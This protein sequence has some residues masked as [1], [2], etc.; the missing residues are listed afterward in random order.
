M[1]RHVVPIVGRGGG[2]VLRRTAGLLVVLIAAGGLAAVDP[3]VA[4]GVPGP[5][6][7]DTVRPAAGTSG[8][9]GGLWPG[10]LVGPYHWLYGVV[11][12]DGS[13]GLAVGVGGVHAA[14]ARRFDGAR[15]VPSHPVA[16]P[17]SPLVG[18][19]ALSADDAWAVGGW[20]DGSALAEHWDGTRWRRVKTPPP[21]PYSHDELTSVTMVSTDDVWAAGFNN[22]SEGWL[23]AIID[24]WDGR[25]WRVALRLPPVRGYNGSFNGISA[26]SADDVWAVGGGVPKTGYL[27]EHWDGHVWTPITVPTP[28]GT[29][30][31]GFDSVDVRSANDVWAVG[32]QYVDHV[33]KTAIVHWNGK[34]WSLV[35]SPNSP[36]LEYPDNELTGVTA[37]SADDVWAVGLAGEH[38]F[39]PSVTL[40]LH[41]DGHRWSRVRSPNV[42]AVANQIWAVDG[43][44]PDDAWAVGYYSDTDFDN[45]QDAYLYLHW[46]GHRWRH[47]PVPDNSP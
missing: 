1:T 23:T 12:I 28:P 26:A 13:A 42:G 22:E 17:Q 41:W 24:H 35:P 3:G 44:S 34:K 46:D 18:V 47:V 19:D 6:V 5:T 20:S 15:W 43:S 37:I 9:P 7:S 8:L 2:M 27:L 31:G 29:Y 38:L 36:N 14:R 4:A 32:A 11:D 10:K 39:L 33:A 45:D 16:G 40:I 30:I 21:P 25:R